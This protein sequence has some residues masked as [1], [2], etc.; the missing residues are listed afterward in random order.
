MKRTILTLGLLVILPLLMGADD[1][2][3]AA[4]NLL[5]PD[6]IKDNPITY[7]KQDVMRTYDYGH[8]DAPLGT[9]RVY[10]HVSTPTYYIYQPDPQNN[11]GVG[12]V[13]LPGGGYRDI[14]LDTEGHDIGLFFKE[15]GITSLVVKYRTN[16]AVN[17]ERTLMEDKDYVPYAVADAREG[18]RILR[19]R[20]KELKIDPKKIGVGG[21]SAGGHLTLSLCLGPDDKDTHTDPDFAFL[22]YP[23]IE[24]HFEKQV[25]A[26]KDLPPMFIANGQQDL[27]TPPDVCATFYET[28]CKN[29]VPAELHIYGTGEH[30]FTLGLG[31]GYSVVRWTGSFLAWLKDLEMIP[32]PSAKTK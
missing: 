16:S 19:S 20:S 25:P 22:I 1:P 24:P 17:G 6:G 28:L 23:W 5:W 21:F 31:K 14:W 26:A 11:T 32:A 10:S 7:D 13:V 9:C 12:I 27:V 3:I 29:K 2:R 18:I 8:P 30:G 4:S 15:R